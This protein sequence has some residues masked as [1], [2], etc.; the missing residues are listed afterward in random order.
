MR[1]EEEWQH[2]HGDADRMSVEPTSGLG[3]S[4]DPDRRFGDVSAA[5][6]ECLRFERGVAVGDPGWKVLVVA[7]AVGADRP[8]HQLVC[9]QVPVA[10][11][12]QRRC[13]SGKMTK[14]RANHDACSLRRALVPSRLRDKTT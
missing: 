1:G 7:H 11:E 10:G 4:L 8:V 2:Q 3:P 6:V 13:C 12:A 5:T 14:N 9:V